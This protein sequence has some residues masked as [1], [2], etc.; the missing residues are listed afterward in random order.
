MALDRYTHER[1]AHCHIDDC[2]KLAEQL[3]TIERIEVERRRGEQL[4]STLGVLRLLRSLALRHI[5][6]PVLCS[7]Y[8]AVVGRRT[9]GR[10]QRRGPV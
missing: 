2:Q 5:L 10:F 1:L 3:R 7:G 9:A 8:K 4:R 6:T